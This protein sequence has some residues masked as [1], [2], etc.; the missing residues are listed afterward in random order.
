MSEVVKWHGC[1]IE[2]DAPSRARKDYSGVT[3]G[4]NLDHKL[5]RESLSPQRQASLTRKETTKW[6]RGAQR[7]GKE[8]GHKTYLNPNDTDGARSAGSRKGHERLNC[9]IF[10]SEF[11]KASFDYLVWGWRGFGYGSER[12]DHTTQSQQRSQ[13]RDDQPLITR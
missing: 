2:K 3:T 9:W 4:R 8:G 6:A 5:P 11:A 1:C 7:L 13:G 12:C 10:S